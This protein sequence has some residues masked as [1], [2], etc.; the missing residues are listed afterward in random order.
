MDNKKLLIDAI[1]RD[2]EELFNLLSSLVK[3][4]SENFGSY[5]NEEECPEFVKKYFDELGIEA[6]VYSPLEIPG[7]KNH[8]DYLDGRNLE[9]RNNSAA[10]VPGKKGDKKLMLAAH[11][12]TVAVGDL[13][14]WEKDPFSGEIKDGIIYGRGSC[15]DK[16]G[17]AI[18]MF[19]IKKLKELGLELDY[20]LLF[21]GYCDEEHG[22][23]HGAL[24]A[25]LKY[26]CDD[27][28]NLDGREKQ[29][30]DSGVGGG[31]IVFSVKSKTSENNC[32]K[33]L[34]GMYLLVDKLEAFKTRRVTELEENPIF[35]G[36]A[37]AKNGMRIMYFVVGGPGG[38]N[39][40]TGSFS[41]TIYTDKTEAEIDAE[42]AEIVDSVADDFEKLGL[43][44]PIIT[45]T[46]RFFHY[47]ENKEP[48]VVA[49]RLMEIAPKYNV[50]L[51]RIGA[52]LSDLPMFALYG[53][54]RSVSL[55]LGGEFDRKGGAHQTNEY[56]ECDKLVAFTKMIADYIM[57]Y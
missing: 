28:L 44:K 54:P 11:I 24:A 14:K 56:I 31:E 40:D 23:S 43:E 33:V 20:D 13:S 41:L 4:N 30:W 26:P 2:K 3:I 18:S 42:F 9:T 57:E 55:G 46:T 52:C 34:K 49:K 36:S 12:D 25:C 37:V 47:I 35:T 15:D 7:F 32:G 29:I 1:E 6:S 48:T 19:I 51:N 22:G 53:S 38:V 21:T 5:G 50:E 10:V 45:K 27:Y 39:M 17:V 8:P 16:Y